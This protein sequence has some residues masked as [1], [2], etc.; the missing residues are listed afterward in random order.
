MN[1]TTAAK[2][3]DRVINAFP[4]DEQSQVRESFGGSL[5]L[6]IAQTLVASASGKGRIACFELLKASPPISALIRDNK[7]YQLTSMMQISGNAGCRRFDDALMQLV[8]EGKITAET[9][10]L[11]AGSKEMFEPLVSPRFLEEALA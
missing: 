2:A 9:A 1:A 8:R 3:V 6:V 4:A 5:K 10:Y 11:R 7:T